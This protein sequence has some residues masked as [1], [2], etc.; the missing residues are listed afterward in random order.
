MEL[1]EVTRAEDSM[2]GA[3]QGLEIVRCNDAGYATVIVLASTPRSES[4]ACQW[5]SIESGNFVRFVNIP[6]VFDLPSTHFGFIRGFVT[7][8]LA[9]VFLL[10]LDFAKAFGLAGMH[11]LVSQPGTL[12]SYVPD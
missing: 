3:F 5:S 2:T 6:C 12:I 8:M 7:R 9:R 4:R 10:S 1:G 11:A